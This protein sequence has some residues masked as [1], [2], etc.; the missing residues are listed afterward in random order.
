MNGDLPTIRGARELIASRK[1][2]SSDLASLCLDRIA[3]LDRQ[4]NSFVFVDADRALDAA[5]NVDRELRDGR[6][7]GPLHGIPYALKDVFDVAGVTTT[8]GSRAFGSNVATRN[9]AVVDRLDEAGAIFLGKLA[10][11]ELTHG[12][13]SADLPWPPARNPWNV[14]HDTGGSSTGAG[15]AVAAGLC[16]F[17]LGTDT[18]GSVRSPAALCGVAGLKPTY[19]R[20]SRQG[21]MLNSYTLDHCGILAWT[22][23]DCLDVFDVVSDRSSRDAGHSGLFPQ[24]TGHTRD[25]V[26]SGARVGVVSSRWLDGATVNPDV[27]ARMAQ[28]VSTLENLGATISVVDLPSLTTYNTCKLSIQRPEFFDLYGPLIRE[29][30]QEF[31][32]KLRSRVTG[33]EA[34][35]AVDYLEARGVRRLLRQQMVDV[36]AGLDVIV[37]PAALAPAPR[38]SDSIARTDLNG[39]DIAIPF[40]VTGFPAASI[41]IGF[42]SNGLPVA[43]QVVSKPFEEQLLLGVCSAYERATPWRQRRP[44][45]ALSQ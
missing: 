37:T 17:A 2:S 10:T 29:R 16:L 44:A 30:P 43:M 35:T 40:N 12:G 33:Y 24:R 15:A 28:A 6:R 14:E 23:D 13:V 41:C 8:G 36:M 32:A 27:E 20:V 3:T 26:M 5:R 22:A 38:L 31:S 25:A 34:I 9:A 45:M 4:L 21:V 18:G 11:H 1:L 42:A 39:P 7:R 19:G